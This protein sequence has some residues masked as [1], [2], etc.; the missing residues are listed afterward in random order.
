MALVPVTVSSLLYKSCFIRIKSVPKV[1]LLVETVVFESLSQIA[2]KN[3]KYHPLAP[4]NYC[5]EKMP[6]FLLLVPKIKHFTSG[7]RP[8]QP[9]PLY[10]K[11]RI[12][13]S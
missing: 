13:D 6:H 3:I 12:N 11:V 2:H 7:R 10:L 5:Q 1:S 9:H 4:D 8:P